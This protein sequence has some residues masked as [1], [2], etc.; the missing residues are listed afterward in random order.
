MEE[1]AI[2]VKV[3]NSMDCKWTEIQ[4]TDLVIAAVIHWLEGEK[5]GA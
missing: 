1:K 5:K 3:A 4:H 2:L